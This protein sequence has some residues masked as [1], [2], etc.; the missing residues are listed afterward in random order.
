MAQD[1]IDKQIDGASIKRR[2]NG[3][4]RY[5]GWGVPVVQIRGKGFVVQEV[6]IWW[7]V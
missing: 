2:N 4:R 5:F 6:P 1:E 7:L 3:Q